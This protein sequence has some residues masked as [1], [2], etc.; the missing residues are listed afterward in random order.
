MPRPSTLALVVALAASGTVLAQGDPV[1][2]SADPG[3]LGAERLLD[4]APPVRD[5]RRWLEERGLTLELAYTGEVLASVRGGATTDEAVVYGGLLDA[6]LRLDTGT[7]GPWPGGVALVRGLNRHGRS[8]APRVGAAQE[9][10]DIEA[11]AVE[12]FT[13]LA[14]AWFRQELLDGRL[15]LK[16][17]KQ[18]VTDHFTGSVHAGRG[19]VIHSSAGNPPNI[20]LATYPDADWG[21]SL[22]LRWPDR[23]ALTLGAFDGVPDGGRS[24]G[25]AFARLRGPMLLAQLDLHAAPLDLPGRLRLGAWWNDAAVPALDRPGREPASYG[26]YAIADQWLWREPATE[27]QGLALFLQYSWAPPDRTE[28]PHY[29]GGGLRWV[30]LLPTRGRDVLGLAVYHARFS[31]HLALPRNETAVELAY[32]FVPVPWLTVRL[33]AQVIVD[34]GGSRED[35]ALVLGA[36]T[37]IEF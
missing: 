1:D 7:A 17:G 5:G 34:P 20:P 18:E 4:A 31:R 24:L 8:V 22:G 11:P 14:E 13:R 10:T 21:A 19:D 35:P 25:E 26:V 33:D 23:A 3:L 9:V 6:A 32:T 29:A 16:V 37:G 12:P 2:P 36:R 27:D 28:V 15:W 30:G